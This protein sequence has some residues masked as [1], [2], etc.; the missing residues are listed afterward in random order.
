MFVTSSSHSK[1]G[2]DILEMSNT[3]VFDSDTLG[4]LH[5]KFVRYATN[6]LGGVNCIC[7]TQ[8]LLVPTRNIVCFH[9]SS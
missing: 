7:L 8:I 1:S 6:M 4:G 9:I 2:I 5:F 3:I